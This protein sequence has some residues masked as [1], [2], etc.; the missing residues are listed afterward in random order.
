[1]EG[2]LCRGYT[3]N[4]PYKK[5]PGSLMKTKDPFS[6]ALYINEKFNGY[7]LTYTRPVVSAMIFKKKTRPKCTGLKELK[8]SL[9]FT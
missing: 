2:C 1:M 4:Y 3:W 7:S 9:G 6:F 5:G 8:S